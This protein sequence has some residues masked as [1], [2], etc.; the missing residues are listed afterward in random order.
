MYKLY[1]RE[2]YY[3]FEEH[4]SWECF[5]KRRQWEFDRRKKKGLVNPGEELPDPME[6]DKAK[7]FTEYVAYQQGRIERFDIRNTQ[8]HPMC[9]WTRK[10][11][12]KVLVDRLHAIERQLQ[13]IQEEQRTKSALEKAPASSTA[14][15]V[16][17]DG[18]TP[19]K[20]FAHKKSTFGAQSIKQVKRKADAEVHTSTAKRRA[21][22]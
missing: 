15:R 22:D 6:M 12:Q 14:G 3:W 7:L 11:E 19:P 4:R 21:S 1:S 16:C 9:N 13:E 18:T 5:L 20:C 2:R 17:R 10:W 8:A